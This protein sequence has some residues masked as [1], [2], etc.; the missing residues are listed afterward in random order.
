MR[1]TADPSV[2]L[3]KLHFLRQQ[4]QL[5][6]CGST[7]FC[8][9][10]LHSFCT[11]TL[12]RRGVRA[13]ICGSSLRR[14]A[15]RSEEHDKMSSANWGVQPG[16]CAVFLRG[17]I[18]L[19]VCDWSCLR[20]QLRW[21]FNPSPLSFRGFQP[22][23]K[24]IRWMEFFQVQ[25]YLTDGLNNPSW[26]YRTNSY[27]LKMLFFF[28]PL[29]PGWLKPILTYRAF[30]RK[31][32]RGGNMLPSTLRFHAS[33]YIRRYNDMRY[34]NCNFH[35]KNKHYYLPIKENTSGRTML[36]VTVVQLE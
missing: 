1:F 4:A 5:L 13:I 17:F 20:Q 24:K 23:S 6:V 11:A 26:E 3:K 7:W 9:T 8:L 2:F 10:C 18:I 21:H 31:G 36:L 22:S 29:V 30:S 32:Y 35:I 27:A 12:Q 25:D 19:L 33:T 28:F 34:W 15:Q 14:S 16:H